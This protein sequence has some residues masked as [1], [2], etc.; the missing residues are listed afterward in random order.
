MK[1]FSLTSLI[2]FLAIFNTLAQDT[3]GQK[4][5]LIGTKAPSFKAPSTN[6][7]ISFPGD[8]EG[9]WKILF[10]HPRD[11]TPV[12]SSELLE[13]AYLQDEFA[14]LNTQIVVI[15]VDRM[16]SHLSWKADLEDIDYKGRGKIKI[17]FPLVVDSSS[18]IS[19]SYGMIDPAIKQDQTVRGVFYID[20]EN[21]IRA[22]QFYPSEVGRNTDEIIRALKALQAHDKNPHT[23]YPGNWKPGADVMIPILTP[24]DKLELQKPDSKIHFI[25]WYMIFMK[26]E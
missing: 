17:N 12:C 23:V 26:N 24:E 5:P 1:H 10:S 7:M 18:S 16:V 21:R 9:K 4:I 11:F 13:L 14:A 19:Y 8:F 15:S 2:L 20:P 6:G 25:N 3:Q 22:F